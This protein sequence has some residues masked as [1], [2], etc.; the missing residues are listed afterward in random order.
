MAIGLIRTPQHCRSGKIY[1]V[2]LIK[3]WKDAKGIGESSQLREASYLDE[4]EGTWEENPTDRETGGPG[5][6]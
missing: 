6:S 5:T 1:F 4:E 3:N 2:D